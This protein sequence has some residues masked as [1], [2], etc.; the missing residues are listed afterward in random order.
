LLTWYPKGN[1]NLYTTT[2][3]ISA[4]E[5][6]DN[7]MVIDQLIGGKVLKKL[8]IEGYVTLGEMKNYNEKNAFIVQNSGDTIKFRTGL[9]IILLLSEKIELSFRYIYLQE[10]GYRITWTAITGLQINSV[11]YQNNTIIGGIK[12][13]L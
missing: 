13:T 10:E 7:R 2:S 11:E 9:N 6:G 1:P 4:W 8:W 12:W 3:F 5:D